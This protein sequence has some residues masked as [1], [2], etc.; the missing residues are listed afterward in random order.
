MNHIRSY[1]PFTMFR[2]VRSFEHF[3]K[4]QRKSY[5]I[6]RMVNHLERVVKRGGGWGNIGQNK[7]LVFFIDHFRGNFVPRSKRG[8][9]EKCR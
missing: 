2:G 8:K 5:Y 1:T 6:I 4:G 3:R 7:R 9:E